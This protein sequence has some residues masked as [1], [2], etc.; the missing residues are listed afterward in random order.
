MFDLRSTDYFG[1]RTR[2]LINFDFEGPMQFLVG[3]SGYS[4]DAWKGG[5]YPPGLPQKQMLN[6]YAQRLSAVEINYTFRTLPSEQVLASWMQQTPAGFRFVLKAPQAITHFK[7]LKGVE[8]QAD[9]F[10]RTALALNGRLGPVLFQ[11]PPNFRKDL[12]RLESFLNHLGRRVLAAFEFRHESWNDDETVGCL[13]AHSCALCVADDDEVSATNLVKTA[14]WGYVR[15]RR[16]A[17]TDD[18]LMGWARR[19]D[20]HGWREAYVFFKHEDTGT[21]PELAARFLNLLD[22]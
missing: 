2:A 20:S 8:E 21:G 12:S 16:Q 9:Q 22:R 7:R 10:I 18:E 4:Y 13:R 1:R 5:F 3:T 6:H 11:L 17:Y 19:L 15:L 14:D